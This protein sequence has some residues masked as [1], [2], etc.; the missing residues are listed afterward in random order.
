ML[1]RIMWRDVLFVYLFGN[2]T[3]TEG[4]CLH[5]HCW[6][7]DRLLLRRIQQRREGHVALWY[8]SKEAVLHLSPKRRV[9]KRITY[10]LLVILSDPPMWECYTSIETLTWCLWLRGREDTTPTFAL[11]LLARRAEIQIWRNQISNVISSHVQYTRRDIVIHVFVFVLISLLLV[12]RSVVMC[13]ISIIL[14][15]LHNHFKH[16]YVGFFLCSVVCFPGTSTSV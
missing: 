7:P 14:W 4:A 6:G 5:P 15:V 11:N 10:W 1:Q 16:G 12:H 8:F 9:K 2:T 13:D 3:L